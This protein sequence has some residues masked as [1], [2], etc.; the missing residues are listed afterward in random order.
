MSGRL[1]KQSSQEQDISQITK[2]LYDSM[3]RETDLKDQLKFIEEEAKSNRRKLEELEEENENLSIQL[4]KM[5]VAHASMKKESFG[6]ST[7]GMNSSE[8]RVELKV[9]LE[10]NEQELLVSK[11]KVHDIENENEKLKEEVKRLTK[12]MHDK[13]VL[14]NV[15]PEPSSPNSYYE[16]KIKESASEIDELRWKL[17]EK[18]R[19]IER[20][21]TQAVV[22]SRQNKLRKSRSIEGDNSLVNDLRKQMEALQ[23][24]NIILKARG[25]RLQ[26]DVEIGLEKNRVLQEKLSESRDLGVMCD[27]CGKSTENPW[28]HEKNVNQQQ[29]VSTGVNGETKSNV[30]HI[31]PTIKIT[32]DNELQSRDSTCDSTSNYQVVNQNPEIIELQSKVLS[33][34]CENKRLKY[35][36]STIPDDNLSQGNASLPDQKAMEDSPSS[37]I[38]MLLNEQITSDS[39]ESREHFLDQILD[40]EEEIGKF[41]PFPRNSIVITWCIILN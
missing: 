1:S 19:D 4:K 22:Q 39:K 15:M 20:L 31:A 9:Q 23:Q 2:D 36:I 28:S 38:S 33:L 8:E 10:L 13:D 5:S 35:R 34:E 37:D 40:M 16:D 30:H 11:K 29:L 21:E 24:D 41:K 27:K 14:L 7:E 26:T 17:I 25:Y 6:F 18:E 12:D 32:S 3:E